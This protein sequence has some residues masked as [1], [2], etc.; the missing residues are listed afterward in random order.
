MRIKTVP[1]RVLDISPP[2]IERLSTGLRK[3]GDINMTV[4]FA[5]GKQL[6]ESLTLGKPVQFD[7]FGWQ[8]DG[9]VTKTEFKE[10]LD[11][12]TTCEVVVRP[13]G[14]PRRKNGRMSQLDKLKGKKRNLFY[15]A[16]PKI[17]NDLT[18]KEPS[19]AKPTLADAI[20]HG[21][22]IMEQEDRDVVLIVK[23]IRVLRRKKPPIL[24]E[25]VGE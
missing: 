17:V 18:S 14:P 24:V 6:E 4:N 13:T 12:L 20:E 23:V 15:V 10:A 21:K 16:H 8:F 3:M 22:E 1:P 19:W 25:K 2:H 9:Y 11:G 7:A 5:T